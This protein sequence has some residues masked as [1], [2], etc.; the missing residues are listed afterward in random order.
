LLDAP[1][2]ESIPVYSGRPMLTPDDLVTDL[3]GLCCPRRVWLLWTDGFNDRKPATPSEWQLVNRSR[4]ADAPA[5][6]GSIFV[7][8]YLR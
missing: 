3:R 4:F 8:E 1:T 5:W 6:K 7:E 2:V